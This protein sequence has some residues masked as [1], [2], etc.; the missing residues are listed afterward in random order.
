MTTIPTVDLRKRDI[1]SG[2]VNSRKFSD[3]ALTFDPISESLSDLELQTISRMTPNQSH[4]I[5]ELRG[6]LY[7]SQRIWNH[8]SDDPD[9]KTWKTIENA[10]EWIREKVPA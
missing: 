6:F 3:F 10:I 1:P 4:E 8:C 2:R 7:N 5:N 9:A